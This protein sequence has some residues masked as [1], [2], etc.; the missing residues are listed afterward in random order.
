MS[1]PEHDLRW[2]LL[3]VRYVVAAWLLKRA[4]H[5]RAKAIAALDRFE[6]R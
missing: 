6:G 2:R 3:H 5:A 1:T 4:Q